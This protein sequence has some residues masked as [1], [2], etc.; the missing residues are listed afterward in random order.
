MKPI[1]GEVWIDNFYP[2]VKF[3]I[4]EII[5]H[6][7]EVRWTFFEERNVMDDF[8]IFITCID[9]FIEHATLFYTVDQM[10]IKDI[11]D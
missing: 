6:T 2:D 9:V 8:S 11:I 10:C 3:E 7:D 1:V 5:D 4:V